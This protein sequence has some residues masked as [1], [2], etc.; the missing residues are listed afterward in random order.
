M[1]HF[2]FD[3]QTVYYRKLH[4]NNSIARQM[5]NTVDTHNIVG[6]K[7]QKWTYSKAEE[8]LAKLLRFYFS[9]IRFCMYGLI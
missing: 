3:A 9:L 8:I 4:R 2:Q 5:L 7:G 1:L 6:S